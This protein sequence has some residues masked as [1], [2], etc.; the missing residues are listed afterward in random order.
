MSSSPGLDF[1]LVGLKTSVL[2]HLRKHPRE[3]S[4]DVAASFLA[5]VVSVLCKKSIDAARRYHR[6]NLVVVGGVA[7]NS[8]LR[9]QMQ[10]DAEEK[11]I[12]VVFP[13]NKYCTDNAA[14]IAAAGAYRHLRLN[15]S[16][17]LKLA[18]QPSLSL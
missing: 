15:E 7:A 14:M 5:S 12:K 13:D 16:H 4:E 2:C 1:N 10:Q 9:K 3:K 6:S 18:P 17:S 8:H 11:Q